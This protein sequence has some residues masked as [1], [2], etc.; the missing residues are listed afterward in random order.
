M[1]V[2]LFFMSLKF[3]MIIHKTNPNWQEKF[4]WVPA[5]FFFLPGNAMMPLRVI[6][7]KIKY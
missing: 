4:P 6:V 7:L 5:N 1:I 3:E 2:L